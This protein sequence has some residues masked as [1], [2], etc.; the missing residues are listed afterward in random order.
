MV[1]TEAARNDVVNVLVVDE[2][3]AYVNYSYSYLKSL[4]GHL[5]SLS[6]SLIQSIISID[7]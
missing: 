2:D 5:N 4:L 7:L 1:R 6:S 3:S